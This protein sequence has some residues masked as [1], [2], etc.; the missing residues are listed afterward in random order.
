M[1][2]EFESKVGVNVFNDFNVKTW[3]KTTPNLYWFIF[4]VL[5]LTFYSV[6]LE[7]A[8]IYYRDNQPLNLACHLYSILL[9]RIVVLVGTISNS[10]LHFGLEVW[11]YTHALKIP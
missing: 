6:E 10:T 9:F 11:N 4:H 5:F 7:N 3:K 1:Y 8:S 2:S